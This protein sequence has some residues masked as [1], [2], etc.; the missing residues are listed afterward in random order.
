MSID[1][2]ARTLRTEIDIA[3]GDRDLV[4][5]MYVEVAFQMK[6]AGGSEVPAAAVVSISDRPPL[7]RW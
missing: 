4:P 3:N 7:S 5:G 1:A 6:N 2:R